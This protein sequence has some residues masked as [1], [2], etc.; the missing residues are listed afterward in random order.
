M[1][2][3]GTFLFLKLNLLYSMNTIRISPFE[4]ACGLK[5]QHALELIPLPQATQVTTDGETYS[6]HIQKVHEKWLGQ[7]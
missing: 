3:H 5:P 6:D 2:C 1:Q 4:A 7:L